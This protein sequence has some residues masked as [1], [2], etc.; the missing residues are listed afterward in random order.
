MVLE[1]VLSHLKRWHA[2]HRHRGG[3]CLEAT[4]WA[5]KQEGARLPWRPWP[6]NTA[7]ANFR[8]LAA[9]PERYGW[10]RAERDGQ[11]GLPVCLVYF[12]ECGRGRGHIGILKGTTIYSNINY[13]MTPWWAERLVGGFV[14]TKGGR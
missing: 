9:D 4:R 6:L 10:T 14:L 8:I 7:L 11:G 1:R 12:N 2:N 13:E 5:L 3:R